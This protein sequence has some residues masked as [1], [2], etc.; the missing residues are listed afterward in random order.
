MTLRVLLTGFEPFGGEAINPSW[1]LARA[2]ADAPSPHEQITLCAERLPVD[3][4]TY[5]QALMRAIE[6]Q[7]PDV[8][9]ALGQATGRA[10]IQLERLA[11]NSL[12]YKGNPDNGGHVVNGELLH[13]DAP[14]TLASS[15]PLQSL[16]ATLQAAGHPVELSADAGRFLCNA[17]LYELRHVHPA[18]PAAFVHLPLL[19]EQSD[20]RGKDEP[21]L[22]ARI[23]QAC[24]TDLIRQL[25]LQQSE[26][27][28]AV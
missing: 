24:L 13:P 6:R 26:P 5:A 10:A 14:P 12:D 23:T 28:D 21:S 22:A 25:A 4:A 9:L 27:G 11:H 8:V 3:R 1:E 18:L 2:L 7:R 16:C 15:L 19:P 20:R 17:V